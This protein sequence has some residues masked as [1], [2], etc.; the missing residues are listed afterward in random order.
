ML[1]FFLGIKYR[2][3]YKTINNMKKIIY[4]LF[5]IT[6]ITTTGSTAFSQTNKKPAATKSVATKGTTHVIETGYMWPVKGKQ[7]GEGIVCKPQGY[8]EKEFN[9]DN[10]FI[11]APEGSTLVSPTDGIIS[12]I[13]IDYLSSLQY[14]TSYHYDSSK[15]FDEN[16]SAAKKECESD[17]SNKIKTKYLSV[18][19]GIKTAKATV[20]IHGLSGDYKFKTGQKIAKGEEIGKIAYCYNKIDQ[21]AIC[22]TISVNGVSSD[23]MTPFGLKTTFVYP[24]EQKPITSLTKVQAKE[25]F[26]ILIDCIKEEY[27]SLYDVITPE[28][29]DKFI[30]KTNY[31]LDTF[32]KDVP[33]SAI[34]SIVNNTIR[35]VHDSH[36]WRL[37]NG[38][39]D[40]R[41]NVTLQP[42][43]WVGIFNDVMYCTMTTKAYE[44]YFG[45][46]ITSV[47]GY[48]NLDTIR[49]IITKKL[50]Q[51]DAKVQSVPNFSM[52][53]T[54]FGQLIDPKDYKMDVTFADGEKISAPGIDIKKIKGSPFMQMG[55]WMK[56]M[57]INYYPKAN[58]TLK[59]MNDSTAYIGLNSFELSETETDEVCSFIKKC[60][61]KKIRNLVFDVRNNG[62][63]NVDVL[64]KIFGCFI[65]M[66]LKLDGYDMMNKIN[67]ET[68]KYSMNRA[69]DSTRNIS[70]EFADFK[71]R[72][73]KSG[74]YSTSSNSDKDGL[75][76]PDSLIHYSGRLYVL[77]NE[78]SV[79]AATL[80]AALTA[81]SKRGVVVG[82]ETAS[83]YHYMTAVKFS[84]I[85][86]PNSNIGVNLPLI[87]TVFDT[88]I[89]DRFPY[90]RGVLP[91]YE[92]PLTFDNFI[93]NEA[94]AILDRA[95]QLIQ[96]VK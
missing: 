22:L 86:L 84:Q 74:V 71:P 10:L 75:V 20:Y 81:K 34:S 45:K 51:Y 95:M 89:S 29:F 88:E 48:S 61:D 13:S 33:Y 41:K 2:T 38:S 14:S 62:G 85:C 57:Q 30:Q 47:N 53:T 36:I 27:P 63:G 54:G 7:A 52:A 28:E 96:T 80:F 16:I 59:E 87:K 91:D 6:L 35:L 93:G 8:I 73:G 72:P 55:K 76:T 17:K 23:P 78:H 65:S 21:P 9:F 42:Q 37:S 40:S 39:N 5:T 68:F 15:S 79:S 49:S 24:K 26:N 18:C 50:D 19:I 92:V 90:G 3:L 12:S 44:K 58:Y 31:Q 83:A 11:T 4:L 64:M 46:K 70:S 77:A 82:R 43:I 56:F 66:P 1:G 67:F 60:E 69:P 94:D 25:D 32:K